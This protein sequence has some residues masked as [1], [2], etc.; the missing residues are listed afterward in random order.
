M[1]AFLQKW[2]YPFL[3]AKSRFWRI[4]TYSINFAY[5]ST[6]ATSVLLKSSSTKPVERLA[7]FRGGK[8]M[9]IHKKSLI[10]NLS[11]TKKALVANNAAKATKGISVSSSTKSMATMSLAK[12]SPATRSMGTRHP[13]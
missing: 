10:T 3:G 12:K 6:L 13:K 2:A 5:I 1:G 7:N 9:A 11:N 4:F 8:E